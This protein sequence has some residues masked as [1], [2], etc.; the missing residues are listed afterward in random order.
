MAREALYQDLWM[1]DERLRQRTH[2]G[3]AGRAGTMRRQSTPEDADMILLNT[4][5][6]REKGRGEG[7]FRTRTA[8]EPQGGQ[9]GPQDRRGRLRGAG[10]RAK[11]SRSPSAHGGPCRRTPELSSSLPQMADALEAGAG[12]VSSTPSFPKRTS[13]PITLPARPKPLGVD[14]RPFSPCRKAVTSFVLFAWCRI[15]VG[16]EVSRPADRIMGRGKGSGF[17]RCAGDYPSR[18]ERECL[19]RPR[20]GSW[21]AGP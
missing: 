9:A 20:A 11:R 21:R 2:V 8:Q 7:V 14:R 12:S 16:A 6:I 13:F 18:T 10:G 15:L 1:P 19:P 3:G 5:H 4:C 17:G